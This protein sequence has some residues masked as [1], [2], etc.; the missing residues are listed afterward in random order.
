MEEYFLYLIDNFSLTV[1]LM[2]LGVFILT[3]LIKMPIKRATS[4]FNEAKRQGINTLIILIPLVL[5]FLA[6]L[7]YFL[8]ENRPILT[9]SYLSCSLS[10]CIMSITIYLIYARVII[11]IK[12]IISGKINTSTEDKTDIDISSDIQ[13]EQ[14]TEIMDIQKRLED[15]IKLKQLL[16]SQGGIHNITAIVE[17]NKEIASLQAQEQEITKI[18]NQ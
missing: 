9:Y 13:L 15:L 3:S 16:E 1:F 10:V 5:S 14:N 17:T 6:C 8:I 7:V 12:G 11:I 2:S 18:K 4:A